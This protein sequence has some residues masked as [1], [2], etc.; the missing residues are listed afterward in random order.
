MHTLVLGGGQEDVLA[1]ADSAEQ[2]GQFRPASRVILPANTLGWQPSHRTSLPLATPRLIRIDHLH[3]AFPNRQANGIR[4]VLTQPAYVLQ[5]WLD[6]LIPGDRIVATASRDALATDAPEIL[7]GRGPWRQFVRVDRTSA[8][9]VGGH[10]RPSRDEEHSELVRLAA[11]FW[12]TSPPERLAACAEI[13]AT[14]PA[15][16]VAALALASTARE[17]ND[18]PLARRA[19]DAALSLAPEWEAVHYEDAKFWLAADDFERARDGFRAAVDR[20]PTFAAAWSNLGA[21]LGELGDAE[22]ALDAFTRAL[23]LEPD[24]IALLN[25]LAVVNREA[26]RLDDSLEVLERLVT[27]APGFVFAHYN[28]GHSRFLRGDFAGALRAYEEGQRLDPEKNRR[29]GCRLAVVR[30]ALGDL[31]GATRDLWLYADAAAA[32]EREDLLLEAY[33]VADALIKAHPELIACHRFLTRI[34]EEL[35]L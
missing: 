14:A 20:M 30:F 31:D 34:A 8:A 18:P 13:R 10:T 16:A 23:A 5:T 6:V 25:N 22:P 1:A 29:Q 19:L 35:T 2:A 15:S 21:T 26:G 33:E 24:N 4:L 28:L 9:G 12:M 3:D 11:A 17:V 27:L 32:D 7:A